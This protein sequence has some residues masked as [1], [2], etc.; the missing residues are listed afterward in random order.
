MK[1]RPNLDELIE[2]IQK[3]IDENQRSLLRCIPTG[4]TKTTVGKVVVSLV[5]RGTVSFS[6]KTN[7]EQL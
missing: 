2:D 7:K 3:M 4:A 5:M 6:T 1:E